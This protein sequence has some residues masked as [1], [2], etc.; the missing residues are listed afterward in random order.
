M[1][2]MEKQPTPLFLER[3][4]AHHAKKLEDRHKAEER[5]RAILLAL[6]MAS[7]ALK[8]SALVTRRRRAARKSALDRIEDFIF[9]E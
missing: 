3:I 9:G 1:R 7:V 5:R 6:D 2:K 8:A 4:R